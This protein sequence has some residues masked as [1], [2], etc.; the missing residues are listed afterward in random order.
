MKKRNIIFILLMTSLIISST[1][2]PNA[3]Y[4]TTNQDSLHYQVSV[5]VKLLPV[6]AQ[7][8][9]GN[10]VYDL[11]RDELE[12]LVNGKKQPIA[13]F[14]RFS[15]DY[16][17]TVS[18]KMTLDLPGIQQAK[19]PERL[20]FIIMDRV[21]NSK[22][23]IRR[24]KQIASRLINDSGPDE[25]FVLL[26][27]HPGAGLHFIVGPEKNKKVLL[28]SIKKISNVT[29]NWDKKLFKT[30]KGLPGV[31]DGY[32]T[33]YE[34]GSRGIRKLMKQVE[35]QRFQHN[36]RRFSHVLSRFKYAL[37]TITCPK[38]TYLISEGPYSIAFTK[39]YKGKVKITAGDQEEDSRFYKTSL[40]RYFK[41]ISKA[42]NEG[43]SVLHTINPQILT[44]SIDKNF[45][46]EMGL[47]YMAREGGGQYFSGSK[48]E[49]V[50]TNIK[51]ATAAY[52]ELAIAI[53]GDTAE[54]MKLKLHCKR[55]GVR[56]YSPGYAEKDIPY[57][58]MKEVQKKL[59]AFDAMNN[60]DWSRI[61]GS[62]AKLGL[63]KL[64][65]QK[66]GDHRSYTF[67]AAIPQDLIGKKADLFFIQYNPMTH[68]VQMKLKRQKLTERIEASIDGQKDEQL[69]LVLIEPEN[70]VCLVGQVR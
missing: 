63:K 30:N 12:L 67:E 7:D 35:T 61:A 22:E 52:Y 65:G 37:H 64:S 40:F 59:F 21:F 54:R 31:S 11:R 10:P 34:L 20:I 58:K 17:E 41:D 39:G 9:D 50:I 15:I 66:N 55:P 28:K 27:N 60:G 1:T 56:V 69:N 32:N 44:E 18:R 42:V 33:T 45:S 62:V 23:G 29:Q 3:I 38:I 43:G 19:K 4:G 14:T 47:S 25:R 49:Q 24:A 8:E 51:R 13:Q 5:E 68:K 2:K 70:T 48:I 6:F 26:D 53:K 36:M 46:G 57:R 16:D